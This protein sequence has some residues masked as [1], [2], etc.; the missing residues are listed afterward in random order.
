MEKSNA[1]KL[2]H[3]G[4]RKKS[5]KTKWKLSFFIRAAEVDGH[6]RSLRDLEQ[7]SVATN[8]ISVG[9][10]TYI[11]THAITYI[12]RV[13]FLFR[14]GDSRS[15]HYITQCPFWWVVLTSYSVI[16]NVIYSWP[17]YLSVPDRASSSDSIR[18][19]RRNISNKWNANVIHQ[20][21]PRQ[22]HGRRQKRPYSS[23]TYRDILAIH[24]HVL[25]VFPH[26]GPRKPI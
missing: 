19:F 11:P 8:P 6:I 2:S 1:W 20:R 25:A 5:L 22:G 16:D 7:Y 13:S 4:W 24:S 23:V 15:S 17:R 26:Q 9:R 3:L 14:N 21:A 18:R 12:L 10:A